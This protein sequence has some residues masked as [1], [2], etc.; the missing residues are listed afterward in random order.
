M[1]RPGLT[2]HRKFRRLSRSLGSAII[3]RG[4]LELLWEACYDSGD[5][6]LGTGEDIENGV[7]WTGPK[8]ELALALVACGLPEGHGFI[9]PCTPDAQ[10][11]AITYRVHDLWH[12]APEYVTKR[13]KRELARRE[14]V[15]PSAKRRRSAPRG[16]QRPPSPDS[17]AGHGETPSPAPAPAPVAVQKPEEQ[18]SVCAETADGGS[19]PPVL[20]F[21]TVGA[22][23]VWF[24]MQADVDEW[25][26]LY[27]NVDILAECRKALAYVRAKP[28][29]RKTARGMPS[30][31]VRWFN[32]AT[33]GRGTGPPLAFPG[34]TAGNPGALQAF[35][36]RKLS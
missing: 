7:G 34:K 4:V 14:K 20:E 6:Y 30:A 13:H 1:G 32:R 8:G 26:R 21:P 17:Q 23:K 22:Q 10:S 25:Q 29:K 35:A 24:L 16:G 33:E 28:A 11:G 36:N 15:A 9:E 27:P 18:V 12:H 5:D 19:P 3:A 31:L 2:N